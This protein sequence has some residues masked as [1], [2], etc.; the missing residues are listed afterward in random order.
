MLLL[1]RSPRLYRRSEE[2]TRTGFGL[3]HGSDHVVF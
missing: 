1:Q 2:R 3:D